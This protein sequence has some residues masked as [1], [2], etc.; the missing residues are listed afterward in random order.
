MQAL[1]ERILMAFLKV[2]EHGMVKLGV[3]TSSHQR[4]EN[5]MFRHFPG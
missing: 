3:L 1:G 5:L 4:D 2:S